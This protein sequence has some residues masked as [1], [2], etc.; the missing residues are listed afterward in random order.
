MAQVFKVSILGSGVS[1]EVWSVNPCFHLITEPDLTFDQMNTIASAINALT[2]PTDLRV[3]FPSSVAITGVRLEQR[4]STGAL[5]RQLEQTRTT[6]VA[7]TGLV[8]HPIQTA[9]VFSLITSTPGASGRGRLYWPASGAQILASTLR[10]DSATVTP[11]LAAME[12]YLSGIENAI[13]A[14]AGT[15]PLS[16]WS[17]KTLGMQGVIRLR[18]GNVPDVQRRR[19]DAL[20]ETYASVDYTP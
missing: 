14:T 8:S 11:A 13:E 15:A 5:V 7:G 16:V 18:V 2:V 9:M 10:F 4:E 20:V 6:P 19:R 12:T 3:L 1:G 17:R